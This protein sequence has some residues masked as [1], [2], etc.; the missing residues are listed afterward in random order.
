MM[1]VWVV[2]RLVLVRQEMVGQGHHTK[3]EMVAMLDVSRVRH[4]TGS[5]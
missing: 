3:N 1:L 4:S 5:G 2:V